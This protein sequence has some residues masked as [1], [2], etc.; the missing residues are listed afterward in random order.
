MEPST[1]IKLEWSEGFG[2][3]MSLFIGGWLFGDNLQWPRTQTPLSLFSL[4]S[5]VSLSFHAPRL[6]Q[7]YAM[8][9]TKHCCLLNVLAPI[10]GV[11]LPSGWLSFG[12]ASMSCGISSP[13]V[14]M[15]LEWPRP[16]P[17]YRILSNKGALSNKSAPPL[18]LLHFII[19][20]GIFP[21]YFSFQL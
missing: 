6:V 21:L 7:D 14:Y 19:L 2:R 18:F 1:I 20:L 10:A 8:N 9:G 15:L 11:R 12:T 13:A 5:S 4:T 16:K 3:T 17:I